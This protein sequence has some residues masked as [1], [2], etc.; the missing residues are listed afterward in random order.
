MVA[1]SKYRGEF[2][3]R[4]KNMLDEAV[5]DPNVILF[6]DEIHTLVGAGDTQGGSMDAA[7]IMKPLL[8]KN[9]LQ[10]IGATTLDEYSKFI[11]KDHALERRFQKGRVRNC[12]RSPIRTGPGRTAALTARGPKG[13][14]CAAKSAA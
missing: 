1:G 8:T 4:I 3:E 12:P 5:A 11:E 10:I 13:W 7:N 14:K 9:E 6:I 2:E